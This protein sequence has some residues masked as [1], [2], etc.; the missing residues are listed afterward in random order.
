MYTVKCSLIKV[1]DGKEYEITTSYGS[2]NTREGRNGRQSAY[3]GANSALKMAQKRALVSAALSLGCMSNTFTQD[4]ESDGE[5]VKALYTTKS[6][7]K[8][9]PQQVTY[10]YTICTRNGV[11]KK[12]AHDILSSYG[13]GSAKDITG[14]KFDEICEAIANKG[15]NE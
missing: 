7:D 2:A 12:Q 1:V 8:I 15:E 9:T 6:S 4:I 5:D 11:T 3:D 10:F 13:F 14:G